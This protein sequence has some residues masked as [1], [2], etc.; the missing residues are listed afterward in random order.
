MTY[1]NTVTM[2]KETLPFNVNPKFACNLNN[3]VGKLGVLELMKEKSMCPGPKYFAP[4]ISA[5]TGAKNIE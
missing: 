5:F 1:L 3:L 2:K 4:F